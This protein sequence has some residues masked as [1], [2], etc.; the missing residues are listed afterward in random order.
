MAIRINLN[1]R[2]FLFFIL[3]ILIFSSQEI[4]EINLVIE[5]EGHLNILNSQ[6]PY[7]PSDF[8]ING[9]SFFYCKKS[10]SFAEDSNKV[11]L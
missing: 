10:C 3:S 7:E 6:F 8:L 11:T 2:A 1:L 4:S 9:I 5:G